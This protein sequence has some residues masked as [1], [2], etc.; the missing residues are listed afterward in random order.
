VRAQAVPCGLLVVDELGP[1]EFERAQGW[2]SGLTALDSGEYELGLVVIRPEL[3]GAA[4]ARW[5][6][7]GIKNL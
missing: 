1:L 6:E 4:L 2:L 5:P 7:A 3:M